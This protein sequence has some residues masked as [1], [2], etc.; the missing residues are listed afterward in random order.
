MSIGVD[1]PNLYAAFV[2]L[3]A[4]ALRDGGQLV[5][6]T[7]RSFTNGPYFGH[8]R[9]Y[10]LRTL[11]IDRIHIFDSRS[12]VF[13]DTGVLQENI[14]FSGTKGGERTK[15]RLSVSDAATDTAVEDLVDYDDLVRPDDPH[16]FIRL[17][18]LADAN[19]ATGMAS[20]PSTLSDLG[21]SVSTGRVVD[22]RARDKLRDEPDSTCVPLIYPAN[23]R[24]GLV[25][26][27]R[28]IRKPQG[29]AVSDES[30]RRKFLLPAGFYVLVKRFSA[31][32]ERRRIVAA[33][34]D[35]DAYGGTDL[36]LENHINV[37][38][39]GGTGLDPDVARGLCLWLNSTVVD[40]YFRTFS[41]HTQVN[42]T[43]L[44]TLR[45]P[46]VQTLATLGASAIYPLP[47]QVEVDALVTAATLP[48]PLA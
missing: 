46:S 38:H 7:P 41:G 43:D 45:Y 12:T 37:F 34:W 36:A 10:L 16:E 1:C 18:T 4:D 19:V 39:D 40:Q 26:W 17:A 42:A 47:E 30:D 5:A 14:I 29:F 15:V 32:E 35:K 28:A 3:G 21:L 48:G 20:L 13:S 9:K 2:A 8:F 22:F 31:K 11:S 24:G 23:L 44:R 27:P 6:I 33:V 25:E